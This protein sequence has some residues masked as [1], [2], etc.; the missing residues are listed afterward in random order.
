MRTRFLVFGPVL[1]A[2]ALFACLTAPEDSGSTGQGLSCGSTERPFNGACRTVCSKNAD[3]PAGQHCMSVGP[4]D[5]LCLDYSRCA[6]L[7][8]DSSCAAVAGL[9]SS[10]DPYFQPY[11]LGL[12]TYGQSYDGVAC[13]GD[14]KWQTVP[15]SGDPS[16]GAEWRVTRCRATSAG[17]ALVDGTTS[18]VAEP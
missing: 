3:C 2:L 4:N 12:T 7:G 15:A 18:D 11:G 9:S 10:Y 1:G 14:A 5:T 8:S 17:C 16:C 13:V 6:F